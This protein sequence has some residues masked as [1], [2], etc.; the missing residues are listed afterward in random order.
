MVDTVNFRLTLGEVE[1]VDFLEET[2]CFLHDVAMH[3]YNG[4]T[5][6]TGSLENLRVSASR[7]Q[8]KVKDGSLCKFLL[9][10]NF[11]AMGR[12]D[13]QRAIEKL[14]DSL[15]LPMDRAAV[16]RLDVANNFIVKQPVMT[17][18]NHLG[19]LKNAVRLMQPSSLYYFLNCQKLVFYDK[20]KEQR[21]SGEPIPELY[22]NRN[23]LRYEQRFVKC[24]PMLFNVEAVTAAMLYDEAF[25]MEL[26]NRWLKSYRD[27]QK[28][29]DISYNFKAMN[30]KQQL[31]KMGVL[32]MV[33][34]VGGQV[35]MINQINEAKQ[36]GDLTA[37]QAYDLRQAVN[38]ACK[39]ND[40]LTS[41]NEAIQE[42]DKKILQAVRYY[43]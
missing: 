29:N 8:V 25:Y 41:P 12:A 13:I 5:T 16:M 28:I 3:D 26:Y 19:I 15:H 6:I 32:S 4:N 33:E 24:L 23:V 10:D 20:V 21:A 14:S 36:R 42:L 39:V 30:S 9:G 18:L 1:G 2:P 35:E 38:D 34:R 40:G 7:F 11:K 22:K 43:R 17:Y 27:I 31:Y 37:K